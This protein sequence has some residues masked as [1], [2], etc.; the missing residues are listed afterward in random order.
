MNAP[1]DSH[2]NFT[3]LVLIHDPP[4]PGPPHGITRGSDRSLVYQVKWPVKRQGEGLRRLARRGHKARG[5]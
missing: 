2:P 3:L 1:G 4:P 5:Q